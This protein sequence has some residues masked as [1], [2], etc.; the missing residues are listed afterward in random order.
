MIAF[1]TF[2][3]SPLGLL[4]VVLLIVLF[5]PTIHMRRRSRERTLY[6]LADLP[7]NPLIVILGCPVHSGP[8]RLNL[9]FTAR[10][11]AAAAAYHQLAARA[12]EA[13]S[14][15][16][17][18]L[19][20]GWDEKGEAT[21]MVDALIRANVPADHIELDP[22]AARTIDSIDLLANRQIP[23][24]IV[25]VSQAFHLPRVLFLARQRRLDAW[26]LP[27]AGR[28]RGLRP[29]LRETTAGTRALLDIVLFRR[30]N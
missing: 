8:G 21:E 15:S 9:Y 3:S 6:G 23:G 2:P 11:A 7:P 19:C 1:A 14:V 24:S 20:S 26:A 18:V 13:G 27:A 22:R 10:I 4:F 28:I 12:G 5:L 30:R 25:F 16:P 17:R 29:H